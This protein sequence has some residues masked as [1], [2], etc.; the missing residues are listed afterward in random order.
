MERKTAL[1][2]SNVP[3]DCTPEYLTEWIEGRGY[4]VSAVELVRDQ[5]SGTSPSFAYV[6]LMNPGELREAAWNL[7]GRNLLGRTIRVC[8][9]VPLHAS[10][11]TV[12]KTSASA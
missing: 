7:D 1:L 8:C 4:M 5:V 9:V 2:C 10:V 6:H 12:Q 3:V 11:G